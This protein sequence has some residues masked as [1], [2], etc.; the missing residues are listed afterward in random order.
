MSDLNI[1]L[2]FG[3]IIRKIQNSIKN[4]A[5][6]TI[7]G[8]EG[9]RVSPGL[10]GLVFASMVA[11]RIFIEKFSQNYGGDTI[12]YLLIFYFQNF[13]FF[14]VTF[15][16]VW[17][18]LSFFL[19]VNP[20]KLTGLFLWGSWLIILPPIFD[21]VR[22]GGQLYWSFYLINDF[23]GLW[24]SFYTL[25]GN[26][27]PAIVYFGTKISFI[28][29]II[30]TSFYVY[31]KSK[32]LIKALANGIVVYVIFFMMGSFPSWF[33]FVYYS[34][35]ERLHFFSIS[36][37]KVIGLFA[38][39]VKIMSVAHNNLLNIL[40]FKLN[41]I[42]FF[43]F[44]ILLVFLMVK[45]N[46][47]RFYSFLRENFPKLLFF[48]AIIILLA[49]MGLGFRI[50]P[51]NFQINIF[52]FFAF[53]CLLIAIF[54]ASL[55]AK[56]S[57]AWSRGEPENTPNKQDFFSFLPILIFIS[58][59]GP[60]L[61]SPKFFFIFLAYLL[62]V[63]I[64]SCRP[65]K[66][67]ARLP[68]AEEFFLLLISLLLMFAGYVFLSDNQ[69]LSFFPWRIAIIIMLAITLFAFLKK[70]GSGGGQAGNLRQLLTASA[71]FLFYPLSAH[72]LNESGIFWPSVFM[73]SFSFWLIITESV[74][75]NKHKLGWL[76]VVFLAYLALTAKIIFQTF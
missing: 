36:E 6:K 5:D 28:A 13:L 47:Q 52:A 53:L 14:A 33:S 25:F 58:L 18:W 63:F 7:N 54:S 51:Q 62:I 44:F 31:L 22:T 24:R 65:L 20:A 38:T 76:V 42:Y 45:I 16:L 61:V 60:L 43:L 59:S 64:F 71:F 39:P 55:I 68:L 72:L 2:N 67:F 74:F 8:L 66:I 12:E 32:N 37:F 11:L 41:L 19:K 15:L 50:Y 30:M 1:I 3:R 57:Y 75:I 73:G 40:S 48:F 46:R 10:F 26:L 69:N 17:L 70:I 27:P 49:F 21:L 29:A 35:A 4:I 56:F 34:I 23:S 9:V